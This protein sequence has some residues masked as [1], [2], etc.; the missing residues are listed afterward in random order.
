MNI[1]R[2]LTTTLLSLFVFSSSAV[3]QTACNIE[4][5]EKSI[6]LKGYAEII[7]GDTLWLGIPKI[8]L[9]GI[10]ALE[11]RQPC[12]KDSKRFKC[13][14]KA[15]DELTTWAQGKELTC[16]VDRGSFGKPVMSHNR[17]LATC[18][19]NGED[20]NRKIVAMGWALA[21]P[22]ETGD[23]YRQYE[24]TARQN[25]LGIH[26]TSYDIPSD[27]RKN[28]RQK[29]KCAD[30]EAVCPAKATEIQ[31]LIPQPKK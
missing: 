21:S 26:Q 9:Y 23:V 29:T 20:L 17:Y 28:Q 22:D 24:L 1:F 13:S 16:N 5:K 31:S 27:F 2:I 15:Y 18:F 8:R 19:L 10:E 4:L 11:A 3:A 12:Y 7:D 14:E 6:I 30:Y 25:K